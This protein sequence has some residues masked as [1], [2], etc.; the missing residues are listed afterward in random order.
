MTT[1][2]ITNGDSVR[3][4]LK[5]F[6]DDPIAIMADP[7][8]EGPAPAGVEGRAWCE[9]RARFLAGGSAEG[10]DD[11][12]REL[13]AWDAGIADATDS[14]EVLLWFEHDLFDQLALIRTLDLLVRVKPDAT[15]TSLICIGEF[16]GVERFVGLGQLNAQQLASLVDR[17]VP[18]TERHYEIASNVWRAFRAPDP[19]DLVQFAAANDRRTATVFPFLEADLRRFLEEY[20]SVRNGLSR[21]AD[22]IVQTL[23][24]SPVTGGQVFVKTQALEPRPFMGDLL[25]Y[26]II[27]DRLAAGDVPLVTIERDAVT[28]REDLR[29]ARVSLTAAGR[30]VAAGRKDAVE[31]NGIDEWRG[32]VHL[33][34]L[35]A[36]PWRWDPAAETLL[37]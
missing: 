5:E 28:A 20:P 16:P 7:L 18:V 4:T 25:I 11:A 10:Y 27:A 31:L 32:G 13:L 23:V 33:R 35:H 12:L 2:H 8:H 3:F 17:R 30:D 6:I 29:T 1:L 19:N 22:A 36:S 21:S 24:D 37:S 14:D 9:L 26:R 15:G 34:G